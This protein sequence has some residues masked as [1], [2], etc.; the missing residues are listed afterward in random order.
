MPEIRHAIDPEEMMAYLDGELPS[1][2]AA[3][4][5]THLERCAE[6]RKLAEDLRRVSQEM[7]A[8]QV[9]PPRTMAPPAAPVDQPKWS[10]RSRIPVP[11]YAFAAAASI[12]LLG[13]IIV[14]P[15]RKAGPT[16]RVAAFSVDGQA[17]PDSS[18]AF[19]RSFAPAPAPLAPPPQAAPAAAKLLP[20][21]TAPMIERTATLNLATRDFDQI[22]SRIDAVLAR[23]HGYIADLN[24]STPQGAGRS[25]NATLRIPAA[26]LDAALTD[27]RQLG[28]VENESQRGEDVT[29]QYADL[30]A[31]LANAHNTE[32]RLAQM[33]AQRTGKLSDVLE[34]EREVSRVRGEIEQMEAERRTT[35]D[36]V[37]FATVQL[38]AGEDYQAQLRLSPDSTLTLLRNAAVEGYRNLAGGLI[39]VAL[40][41]M[42][43]GPSIFLWAALAFLIGLWFV[44]RR[45]A[46]QSL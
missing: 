29:R 23:R 28:R 46:R 15:P 32:E 17:Q 13:L 39:G 30:V 36:Q 1:E 41:L 35:A 20:A 27:L 24:L 22:R 3:E 16:A 34:V 5:M 21:A 12:V 11:A 38:N 18:A 2:R 19:R 8:W 44:R 42:T 4:A 40:V 37:S 14:S 33:L 31:R 7:A 10:L 9:E 6:C 43:Y 25:L 45:K 26:E